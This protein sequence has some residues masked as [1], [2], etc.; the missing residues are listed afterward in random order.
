MLSCNAFVR[1]EIYTKD[2]VNVLVRNINS[3]QEK[4]T[5]KHMKTSQTERFV[6]HR[7]T[8]K[9]TTHC[10]IVQ[11]LERMDVRMIHM[12]LLG[13]SSHDFLN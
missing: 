1:I 7:R 13:G 3:S 9:F 8:Q 6:K 5:L 2:K 11:R 12:W 4:E 10:T